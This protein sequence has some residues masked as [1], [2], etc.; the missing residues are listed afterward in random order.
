MKI[1]HRKISSFLAQKRKDRLNK[2]VLQG[3]ALDLSINDSILDKSSSSIQYALTERSEVQSNA[4]EYAPTIEKA[5]EDGYFTDRVNIPEENLNINENH[6]L[7]EENAPV[8][9]KKNK[10]FD[11]IQEDEND[12]EE[13]NEIIKTSKSEKILNMAKILVTSGVIIGSLIYV[14]KSKK[15][16]KS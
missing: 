8:D 15:S 12:C 6:E 1:R 13:K 11:K 2:S 10:S 5:L 4:D 3:D 16:Y 14:I 7:A 9:V